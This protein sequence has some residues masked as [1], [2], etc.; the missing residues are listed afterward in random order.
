MLLISHHGQVIP[1]SACPPHPALLFPPSADPPRGPSPPQRHLPCNRLEG[2][3]PALAKLET[4]T[5]P[6]PGG[7][8]GPPLTAACPPQQPRYHLPTSLS[9]GSVCSSCPA[10][11]ITNTHNRYI[12]NVSILCL[13]AVGQGLEHVVPGSRALGV[14]LDRSTR[15]VRDSVCQVRSHARFDKEFYVQ[16]VSCLLGSFHSPLEPCPHIAHQVCTASFVPWARLCCPLSQQP[17]WP[18]PALPSSGH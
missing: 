2:P 12:S 3:P 14:L 9:E 8:P 10:Y 15:T 13:F 11:N 1:C 5:S 16:P 6:P 17:W 7:P 4:Q 18:S